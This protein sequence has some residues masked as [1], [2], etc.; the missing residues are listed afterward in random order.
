VET[1]ILFIPP[2]I[3]IH[4]LATYTKLTKTAVDSHK[5]ILYFSLKPWPYNLDFMAITI[6]YYLVY[7]FYELSIFGIAVFFMS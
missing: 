6:S 7:E 2:T 5:K 3:Y 4:N 1:N